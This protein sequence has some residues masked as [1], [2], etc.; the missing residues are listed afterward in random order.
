MCPDVK[1]ISCYRSR[2]TYSQLYDVPHVPHIFY[3][4]SLLQRNAYRR[5]GHCE[6]IYSAWTGLLLMLAA[7][8]YV[9]DSDLLLRAQRRRMSNDD[10]YQQIQAAINCW[11]AI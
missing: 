3:L 9:D 4:A 5:M 6:P 11:G 2:F 10:F 8:I 7:I 1:F